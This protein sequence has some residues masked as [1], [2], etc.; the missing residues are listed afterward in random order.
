MFDL[1]FDPFLNQASL[2]CGILELRTGFPPETPLQSV[3][4]SVKKKKLGGLENEFPRPPAALASYVQKKRQ[5]FNEYYA[6]QIDSRRE[7]R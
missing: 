6:E 1:L 4:P 3:F 5:I 7:G 2:R